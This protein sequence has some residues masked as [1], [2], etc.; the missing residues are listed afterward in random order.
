MP[1]T[2]H[3]QVTPVPP[4]QANP[5]PTGNQPQPQLQPQ[6]I[7][8]NLPQTAPGVY[9]QLQ[10]SVRE[11][12]SPHHQQQHAPIDPAI[13]NMAP[14]YTAEVSPSPHTSSAVP[15]NT[16][17]GR[18]EHYQMSQAKNGLSPHKKSG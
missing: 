14:Y 4:P 9:T 5:F 13:I 7:P 15:Y 18:T 16:L 2:Q 1:H 10:S 11:S 8:K 3:S 6:S 17:D 12:Q